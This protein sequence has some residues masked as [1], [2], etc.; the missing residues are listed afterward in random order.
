MSSLMYTT[1]PDELEVLLT[2]GTP[3]TVHWVDEVNF[4][5]DASA[6]PFMKFVNNK[7]LNPVCSIHPAKSNE[8]NDIVGDHT[9]F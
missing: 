9:T 4:S 3:V 7:K 8:D 6:D 5:A 2:E 1:H